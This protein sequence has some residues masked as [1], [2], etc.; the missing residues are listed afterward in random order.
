MPLS[1]LIDLGGAKLVYR[2]L[3]AIASFVFWMSGY[4]AES[5]ANLKAFIEIFRIKLEGIKF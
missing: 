2:G 4:Q 1:W 5:L 3:A